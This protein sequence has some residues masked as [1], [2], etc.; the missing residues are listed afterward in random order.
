ME[1]ANDKDSEFNVIKKNLVFYRLLIMKKFF[2]SIWNEFVYGGHLLSIGGSAIVLTVILIFDFSLEFGINLIVATYL[3]LQ[4]IYGYNHYSEAAFDLLTNPERAKHYSGSQKKFWIGFVIYS[5]ALLAAL[6]QFPLIA[7][8]LILFMLSGG[9][10]F[11]TFFKSLTQR[12]IGFKSFYTSFFW[13]LL[14]P[15]TFVYYGKA[16]NEGAIIL[17]AFVFIRWLLNTIFFDIKDMVADRNMRLKTF[18]VMI[19]REQTISLLHVLNILSIVPLVFGLLWGDIAKDS[20][21]LLV[22]IFLSLYYLWFSV[23]SSIRQLRVLSYIVVDGEYLLWPL[24]VLLMK[25]TL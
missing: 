17:S 15:L 13:A 9:I 1:V 5:L 6:W 12:I 18:P 24:L 2:L 20:G 8:L 14:V 10:L 23:K 19:G 22:I 16:L 3:I 7:T 4:I 25:V 21:A 11:T